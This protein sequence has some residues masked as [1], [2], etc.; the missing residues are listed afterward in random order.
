MKNEQAKFAFFYMLSLVALVFTAIGFGNI[1]FE[2][3]NKYITDP[4]NQYSD[5]YSDN[6]MKFG[7]S[8]LLIAAPIYYFATRQILKNLFQ[9]NLENDSGIRKWLTYFILLVTSIVVIAWLIATLNSFLDGELTT[10]FILKALTAIGIS[11]IIFAYYFYD[12]KR[13]EVVN[14]KDNIIKIFFYSTLILIIGAFVAS[15]FTVESPAE[16]RNR[17]IDEKIINKF[18]KIE[19]SSYDFYYEHDRLAEN[20]EEILNDSDYLEEDDLVDPLNNER[21]KYNKKSDTEFELCASFR[22]SNLENDDRYGYY[23]KSKL[24][25][26]GYQCLDFKYKVGEGEKG[27]VPLR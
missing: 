25:D 20:L 18:N 4:L 10:K 19:S 1:V 16:A 6:G 27:L 15:F 14:K 26:K 13:G 11:A 23:D 24:H 8:A 3:I 12:I 21:F 2:I 17:R 5:A 9:G 7:I 22:T